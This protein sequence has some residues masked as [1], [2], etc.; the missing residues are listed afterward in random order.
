MDIIN[1]IDI[2]SYKTLFENEIKQKLQIKKKCK[3][4][5]KNGNPCTN[6]PVDNEITCKK[7]KDSKSLVKQKK[8]IIYHNHLPFEKNDNCPLCVK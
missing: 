8:N 7:H 2:Q 5:N 1:E 4:K 3:A 6:C